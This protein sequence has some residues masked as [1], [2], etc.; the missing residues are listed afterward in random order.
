M[1]SQKISLYIIVIK[2]VQPIRE[3][4]VNKNDYFRMGVDYMQDKQDKR[5]AFQEAQQSYEQVNEAYG[6]I[7]KDSADYGSQLKHVGQEI[8]EAYAQIQSAL[9]TASETQRHQ[10]KQ[11][12]ENLRT[13]KEQ[14]ER[15]H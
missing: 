10:L 12:E 1:Q 2:V 7:M 14:V 11:F 15:D 9:V 4:V 8:T 13:I 6:S 3:T 5:R